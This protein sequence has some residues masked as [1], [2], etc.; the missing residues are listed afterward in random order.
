MATAKGQWQPS[1][2]QPPLGPAPTLTLMDGPAICGCPESAECCTQPEA[3]LPALRAG[4]LQRRRHT[5]PPCRATIPC[6]AWGEAMRLPRP[7]RPT[8]RHRLRP[9]DETECVP[10][11]PHASPRPRHPPAAMAQRSRRPAPMVLVQGQWREPSACLACLTHAAGRHRLA[12]VARKVRGAG[13]VRQDV[14][15]GSS[16][17]PNACWRYWR[18]TNAC[19]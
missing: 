3:G 6:P 17:Q 2:M 10:G 13:A 4:R 16:W 14:A 5:P 11:A 9:P 18:R 8:H 1:L 7:Q 15:H 19:W 12:Q